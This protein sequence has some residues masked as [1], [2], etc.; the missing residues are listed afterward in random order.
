MKI[1]IDIAHPA[2]VHLVKNV[3]KELVSKGHRVYVTVKDIPSAI[4]LLQ[5]YSIPYLYLGEKKDSLLG[6]A[7]L[8]IAYNLKVWWMVVSK[9]IDIG[10]GTSI[11]IPHISRVTKMK[12]I[13]FDDDDD[14]VEPLF[15]KYGHPFSDVILSPACA[16]RKTNK[17]IGYN[18]YHELA[19]LHPSR[20]T[21]DVSVLNE[22]GLLPGEKYFIL[23]FN[24]F[25]AHHDIGIQGLS[26]ENKR[27][28]IELL[29]KQGKVFITTERNLDD[30]F[31]PYQLLLSPEKIH[32]LIYYATMFVG[33]SQT[34]T[35]EAAVLGTPSIR[36][37]T[38]VRRISYLEEEEFSYNLTYG[39]LPTDSEAMFSKIKELLDMP[40]LKQEWQLR[41][42]IMLEDK[43]DVTQFFVWFVE[44]YPESSKIMKGNPDYQFNFK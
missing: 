36:C 42:A 20:F 21:P 34:M 44:N 7:L 39:F 9:G 32:S 2:H 38:F 30:E 24:A 41:R 35:S 40:N 26:I 1:L 27:K 18:G 12:S 25:K 8:Q 19:Y 28:I 4:E 43:I 17:V 11:T 14:D 10:F 22:I 16:V 37:N 15:V 33:D 3:Y 31:L 29:E 6:K 13:V 5:R 23:R